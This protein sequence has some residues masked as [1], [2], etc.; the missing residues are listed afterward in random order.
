MADP[1]TQDR[2]LN[3][4]MALVDDE[5]ID[6]LTMRALAKRLGVEAPSLYKHVANKD[7]ILDG[8]C[9]AVFSTAASFAEPQGEAWPDQLRMY[10]SGY[11]ATLLSHPNLTATVATRP[12]LTEPG[13]A[14]VELALFTIQETGLDAETA[15]KLLNVIV[16][17]VTGLVLNE[18]GSVELGG[19][20]SQRVVAFRTSLDPEVYPNTHKTVVD[21]PADHQAEFEMAIDILIAGI[22]DILRRHGLPTPESTAT[23]G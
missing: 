15:R 3:A 21:T 20:N 5:G 1:L 13:M 12:V 19:P 22:S 7:E 18:L 4:A 9:G 23:A 6:A 11:R 8:L 2:I 14:M 10:C 17:T 16:S